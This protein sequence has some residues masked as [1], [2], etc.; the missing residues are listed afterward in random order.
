MCISN[1]LSNLDSIH[2]IQAVTFS[3]LFGIML[4][5]GDAGTDV[6]WGVDLYISGHKKWAFAVLSPVIANTVFTIIACREME[7]SNVRVSWIAYLPLVF[8]QV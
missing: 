2:A 8:L 4:P 1:I 7:K 6:L 5:T 3:I